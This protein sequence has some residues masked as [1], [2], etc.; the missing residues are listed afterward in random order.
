MKNYSWHEFISFKNTTNK[1]DFFC[2]YKNIGA[3]I[4]FFNIIN[5]TDLHYENIIC[6]KKKPYFVDLECV[7]SR[8]SIYVSDFTNTILNTAIIPS[9]AGNPL[10]KHICG[11]GLYDSTGEHLNKKSI[12]MDEKMNIIHSEE[13]L[14]IP[15]MYNRPLMNCNKGD[16]DIIKKKHQ[17][18]VRHNDEG[19]NF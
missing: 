5:G 7:F 18:W 13:K 8:Q 15:N 4:A 16:Y 12:R 6:V 14:K 10:D 1:N 9:L 11:I 19:N 17:F 3:A 2:F